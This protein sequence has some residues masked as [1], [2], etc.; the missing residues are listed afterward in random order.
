M[1]FFSNFLTEVELVE[2]FRRQI[3]QAFREQK[4]GG[5]VVV[6]GGIGDPYPNIYAEIEAIAED[7]GHRRVTGI[8]EIIDDSFR[9]FYF[10]LLKAVGKAVWDH[11]ERTAEG[12]ILPKEGYPQYWDSE[13]P[14]K[15][16]K[17][18]AIRVYRKGRKRHLAEPDMVG[19]ESD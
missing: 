17:M 13:K 2:R 4:P 6:M 10:P 1:I 11:L 5:V 15:E 14:I 7:S 3:Y 12:N 16:L 19:R 18:F 9:R 8:P